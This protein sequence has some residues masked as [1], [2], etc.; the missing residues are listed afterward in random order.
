MTSVAVPAPAPLTRRQLRE[1]ERAREAAELAEAGAAPAPELPAA[2][3]DA[4]T[5]DL[6]VVAPVIDHLPMGATP[7]EE[8][9]EHLRVTVS[10]RD[11]RRPAQPTGTRAGRMAP[12]AAILT[13]LGAL[14]IAAPLTGFVSSSSPAAAIG[15]MVPT[16][17]SVLDTVDSAAAARTLEG[18]LP[19]G[20]ALQYDPTAVTRAAELASRQQARTGVPACAPVEGASGLREAY[21]E[22]DE[23]LYRPMMQGT[24]RDTSVYGPRWGSYHYGTDMAAP[25]GTAIYAVAKGEVIYAG[26]GKEGRS[27]Q[28]VIIHHVIDGVDVYTWYGHMYSGGVYVSA[29]QKV[30]AGEMIAGVGNNGFSTGPH[31]HF[32][33]HV[34][35][36]GNHV[37]PLT[38]LSDSGA[39]FPGS[40]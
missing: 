9:T 32:E 30:E 33:V 34:G 3:T 24:Y 17:V 37:N 6:D 4:P 31:L 16:E 39:V 19:T 28:L 5:D 35:E 36:Y 38:W 40:C 1:L 13:S 27:G 18:S 7:S 22:R 29:G 11:L 26:G 15:P 21:T 2:P 23:V 14:T 10:R 12:R 25:V 20:A 8:L